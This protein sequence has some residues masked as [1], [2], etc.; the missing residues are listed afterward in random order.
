[1]E[2]TQWRTNNRTKNATRAKPNRDVRVKSKAG[3]IKTVLARTKN[4]SIRI[5]IPIR[6]ARNNRRDVA[7][8][9][10]SGVSRSAFRLD[11]G[12]RALAHHSYPFANP[13]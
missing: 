1:M 12:E 2:L 7:F 13:P 4:A 8:L 11:L 3:R 10:R 9:E 6:S 5:A